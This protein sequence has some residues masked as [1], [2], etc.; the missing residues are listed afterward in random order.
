MKEV[1]N[2]EH[3]VLTTHAYEHKI[4]VA[5]FARK[6][7]G[8]K[9]SR[10]SPIKGVLAPGLQCCQRQRPLTHRVDSFSS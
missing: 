5:P 9:V 4:F 10:H 8:C 3:V 1:G 2:V 6:F 7:P